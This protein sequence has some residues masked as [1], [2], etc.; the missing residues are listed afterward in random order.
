VKT[1]SS[2]C[3]AQTKSIEFVANF[4]FHQH[5]SK[6]AVSKNYVKENIKMPKVVCPY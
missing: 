5:H 1:L 4:L 3:V 6:R 2:L